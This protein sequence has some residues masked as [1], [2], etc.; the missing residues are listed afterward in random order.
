MYW[1]GGYRGAKRGRDSPNKTPFVAAVSVDPQGHPDS[2]TMNVVNGIR[3][4]D[5]ARWT[6]LHLSADAHVI[7]DGLACFSAV[8]KA[9]GCQHTAVV[10]GGGPACVTLEAFTCVNTST[11]NV[12]RSVNGAY[13][14]INPKHLPRYLAEF[15]YRFN[16]RF[17][18]KTCC[19]A[20][21][22][23]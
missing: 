9:A 2:M 15:C 5:I 16:R 21:S 23:L 6:K 12:K 1:G 22:T 20:L 14:A 7:S 4:R 17:R 18:L 11:G 13:H 3:A 10:T 19:H 8:V